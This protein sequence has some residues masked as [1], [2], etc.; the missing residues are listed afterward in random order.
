MYYHDICFS[1]KK[2]PKQGKADLK[3]LETKTNQKEFPITKQKKQKERKNP[4]I[5]VRDI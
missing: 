5:G 3:L 2:K 1:L 4:K